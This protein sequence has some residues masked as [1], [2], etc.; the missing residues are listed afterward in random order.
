MK[1]FIAMLLL[2]FT[3]SAADKLTP[4]KVNTMIEALSRLD[5]AVVNGNERLKMVLGQILN[6]T[7]GETR[8]VGLVKKFE[9]KGRESDLLD[10]AAKHPADPAGVQALV[11]VLG[12]EGQ[13][14]VTAILH[15]NDA[16]QA[17]AVAKALGNSNNQKVIP[18]LVPLVTETKIHNNVR[19]EAI[20]GLVNFEEGAKQILTLAK[21][22]KLPQSAKFTA[23]MALRTVRWVDIK[24][25]GAKVLPLPFG[26]N[27]KPLP[28]I[29]ELVKRKGDVINGAKV[30]FRE[31]VTC[32]RCHKVA[33]QGIDVGPA[34]TEIG[35]K[36]PKEELYAAIL[37]PSA[38]ISFGY[39]AW[40]VTMK[41]GNVAFGIIESETPEEISVKG[42]TGVVTRHPKANLKGRMQQTVSLMPPGLHLTMNE[43]ELVDLIEYLASLKKQ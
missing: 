17:A 35:S 31:T 8:F 6:A 27:A 22:G 5:P 4:E 11:M 21:S 10:V 13:K 26:K 32:A 40:L 19:Q 42:P 36:L 43:T 39:E 23:S 2:A 38:G 30:F 20:K 34:L 24:K 28:P 14:A 12:D 3:T 1:W 9:V 29:S 18:L 41:D 37:D 7:R 16:K 25:E 15:G 33:D